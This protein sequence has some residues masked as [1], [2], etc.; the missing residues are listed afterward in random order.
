MPPSEVNELEPEVVCVRAIHAP[1]TG[2]VDSHALMLALLGDLGF[3][4]Y[5]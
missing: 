3:R 4:I 2:I 5:G 1:R